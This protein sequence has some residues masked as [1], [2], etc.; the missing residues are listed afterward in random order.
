MQVWTTFEE[1]NVHVPTERRGYSHSY[2]Y[3][4]VTTTLLATVSAT[5]LATFTTATAWLAP[6]V[7]R[8]GPLDR[9][10]ALSSGV[11]PRTCPEPVRTN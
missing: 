4:T 3:A 6:P 8:F 10:R 7:G 2:S 11:E 5:A 1:S 9:C